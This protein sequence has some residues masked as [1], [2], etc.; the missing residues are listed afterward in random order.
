MANKLN[1]RANKE[2]VGQDQRE[3]KRSDG[4]GEIKGPRRN[5][6]AK[7]ESEGDVDEETKGG[8]MN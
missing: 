2:S 7:K 5:Q 6:R 8:R 3:Y 4:E 1:Q